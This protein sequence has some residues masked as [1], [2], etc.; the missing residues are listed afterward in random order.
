MIIWP[1]LH[2]K[3]N[4]E[5][6]YKWLLR[7]YY[8]AYKTKWVGKRFFLIKANWFSDLETTSS[9]Q[10]HMLHEYNPLWKKNV[11]IKAKRM[12][13]D[14]SSNFQPNENLIVDILC[15]V[16][17]LTWKKY[18]EAHSATHYIVFFTELEPQCSLTK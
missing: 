3:K 18:V 17:K 6:K 15:L 12:G 4:S 13:L 11:Y 8:V 14:L 10:D 5:R 1:D 2:V 7:N 16:I 9:A